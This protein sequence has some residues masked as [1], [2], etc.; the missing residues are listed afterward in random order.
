MFV[1]SQVKPFVFQRNWRDICD[2]CHD[3]ILP[4]ISIHSFM[5]LC[6]SDCYLSL[7]YIRINIYFKSLVEIVIYPYLAAAPYSNSHKTNRERGKGHQRLCV[8]SK[9]NSVLHHSVQVLKQLICKHGAV[10]STR[11]HTLIHHSHITHTSVPVRV[12][13]HECT[14]QCKHFTSNGTKMSASFTSTGSAECGSNKTRTKLRN[15]RRVT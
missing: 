3:R 10:P 12:R 9:E 1:C 2:L 6:F 4:W 13:V 5:D 8:S 11:S 7:L 14:F 15:V